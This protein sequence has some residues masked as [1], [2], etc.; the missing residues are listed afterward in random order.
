[1]WR[2]EIKRN[3]FKIF[4]KC[5]RFLFPSQ[6]LLWLSVCLYEYMPIRTRNPHHCKILYVYTICY[7]ILWVSRGLERKKDGET[8]GPWRGWDRRLAFSILHHQSWKQA[9]HKVDPPHNFVWNQWAS[10]VA[11]VVKNPTASAGDIRDTGLIP[12]LGKIPWRMTQQP[13]P[14]LLPGESHERRSL[15]G[16]VHGLAKS[17]T[18][19]K[20]L[21]T[22]YIVSVKPEKQ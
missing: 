8:R 11:L 10:P 14:V 2:L 6:M 20:Q 3:I 22:M 5:G 16:T 13:T 1:M 18:W 21:S 7:K 17:W 4:F 19:E 12:G 15:V 9:N